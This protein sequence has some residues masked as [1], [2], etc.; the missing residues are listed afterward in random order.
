MSDYRGMMEGLG[1]PVRMDP[2]TAQGIDP[3]LDS[4]CQRE[5]RFDF[6][7][8]QQLFTSQ[9]AGFTTLLEEKLWCDCIASIGYI[10][11]KSFS[12][13]HCFSYFYKD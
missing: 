13:I 7:I 12:S 11:S 3:T 4:C 9:K 10:E 5:V 2:Y 6:S 8:D 1:G